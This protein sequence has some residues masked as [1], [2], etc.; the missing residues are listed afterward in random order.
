MNDHESGAWGSLKDQGLFK[1]LRLL[2]GRWQTTYEWAKLLL[3]TN[4]GATGRQFS[5]F[6]IPKDVWVP[7]TDFRA[8]KLIRTRLPPQPQRIPSDGGDG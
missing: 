4:T 2:N 8:G 3:F 1:K 6:R 5:E 7:R